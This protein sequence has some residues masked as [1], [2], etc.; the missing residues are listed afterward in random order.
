VLPPLLRPRDALEDT[1]LVGASRDEIVEVRLERGGFVLEMARRGAGFFVRRPEERDVPEAAARSFLDGLG[2]AR[3]TLQPPAG[4]VLDGDGSATLR[5][6]S[7]PAAPGDP[8]RVE[9]VHIGP[10][11]DGRRWARR[12]EDGATLVVGDASVRALLTPELVLRDRQ[13]LDVPAE[14]VREIAVDGPQV[15]QRIRRQGTGFELVVPR[16]RGLA[17]DQAW[18][19]DLADRLAKLEA[20]RWAARSP[21]P[22]FGLDP[23][24]FTID[25][26]L[27]RGG[28]EERRTLRFGSPT[29]DGPYAQIDG[30]PAVFVAPAALEEAALRWLVDRGSFRVRPSEVAEIVLHA[31]GAA[32]LTLV[33]VDGALVARG[34]RPEGAARA[35]RAREGLDELAA[36]EAIAIGEARPE[37]GLDDPVLAL[38]VT[39]REGPPFRVAIGASDARDGESLHYARRSDVG[40]VFTV[41][42]AAVQTLL[43]AVR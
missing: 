23:P 24:R 2:A 15:E 16:G 37:H 3:G 9:V 13:I 43:E 8:E 5:I 32:P 36:I 25:V 40:A 21:E 39:P 7:R 10:A 1:R 41:G 42:R 6:V 38:E 34:D 29:D 35:A 31:G 27:A 20:V 19:L 28:P 30:E 11:A 12:E 14:A 4:A 18:A 22:G 26:V 17:A 33:R